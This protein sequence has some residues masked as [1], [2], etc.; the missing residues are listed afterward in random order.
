MN[1]KHDLNILAIVNVGTALEM[2]KTIKAKKYIFIT[3]KK[4]PDSMYPKGYVN[5]K[6][7]FCYS[8]RRMKRGSFYVKMDWQKVKPLD[9]SLIEKMYKIESEV[10]RMVDRIPPVKGSYESR[11]TYYMDNLRY[12]SHV[13]KQHKINVFYRCAP[14]HEGYDHVIYGICKAFNIPTWLFGPF[15]P[16]LAYFSRSIE[17]PFPNVTNIMYDKNLD[18]LEDVPKLI[19]ELSNL[20]ENHWSK[21]KPAKMPV[22]I[23]RRKRKTQKTLLHKFRSALIWY[24]QN[25]VKPNFDKPY[26]YVPLHFQYEATTCPLGGAFVDQTLMVSLLSRLGIQ[27]YVKEHA[28]MSKNR[29]I[30]FYKKMNT[31]KNVN[32]ISQKEDNYKLIDNCFCVANITGTAGWEAVL[33]GKQTLLFGH[34]FHQYVPY[35]HKVN[36]M[37]SLKTAIDRIKKMK[38]YKKIIEL[39]LYDLQKYLFKHKISNIVEAFKRDLESE[40]LLTGNIKKPISMN[41]EFSV[42]WKDF[43]QSDESIDPWKIDDPSKIDHWKNGDSPCKNNETDDT[44]ELDDY[45]MEDTND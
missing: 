4:I 14:P 9:V 11:K 13:I 1:V 31:L 19:P 36:D 29:G 16:G 15:H 26:I 10:L 38:P 40:F 20:L 39:F 35:V 22:V 42:D 7:V 17:D 33:R 12:W 5:G 24:Q 3:T 6:N 32:L 21:K 23:P 34:I 37:E 44:S 41:N 45:E 43:E 28:R 30:S 27:I 2:M 25:C 8:H 18:T